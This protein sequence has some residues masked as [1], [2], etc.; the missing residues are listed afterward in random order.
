MKISQNET[1]AIGNVM[2]SA[3]G[4]NQLEAG[5]TALSNTAFE[6]LLPVQLDPE[7]Q[8]AN[9]YDQIFY[10]RRKPV[11][12][13]VVS[14]AMY[15]ELVRYLATV[16]GRI[17]A[18]FAQAR[19]LVSEARDLSTLPKDMAMTRAD[20]Y[21]STILKRAD[22]KD[23][24]ATAT[25]NYLE[26]IGTGKAH[27][28]KPSKKYKDG[29]DVIY[30]GLPAYGNTKGT[31]IDRFV[32]Q[33]LNHVM[34][35]GLRDYAYNNDLRGDS[36][37]LNTISLAKQSLVMCRELLTDLFDDATVGTVATLH[38]R[39][40]RLLPLDTDFAKLVNGAITAM[41]GQGVDMRELANI[42]KIDPNMVKGLGRYFSI[43][44]IYEANRRAVNQRINDAA[45]TPEG[46]GLN[47]DA[48]VLQPSI[49]FSLAIHLPSELVSFIT[50]TKPSERVPLTPLNTWA[51]IWTRALMRV[52]KAKAKKGER[53]TVLGAPRYVLSA[54][55]TADLIAR[56]KQLGF[57]TEEGRTNEDD[58]YVSN[59]GTFNFCPKSSELAMENA[60]N[61]ERL[62]EEALQV[63]FDAGTPLNASQLGETNPV[64]SLA[65]PEY[66]EK[67]ANMK[68]SLKRY[69]GSV[70]TYSWDYN[71][72]LT[73][74]KQDPDKL[75]AVNLAGAARPDELSIADYLRRPFANAMIKLF[76]DAKVGDE[77]EQNADPNKAPTK[78][79]SEETF[80]K[81]GT[82]MPMLRSSIFLNARKVYQY[83]LHDRSVP[84]FEQ[85][86]ENAAKAL[87]ITSLE[88]ERVIAYEKNLS[89][90]LLTADLKVAPTLKADTATPQRQVEA[91]WTLFERALRDSSGYPGS[92]LARACY[93]Q[94]ENIDENDH[95]FNAEHFTLAEFK[96]VYNYFGGQVFYQMLTALAHVD[97]KKLMVVNLENPEP[98]VNFKS[99][100]EEVM[101]LAM[102]MSKYVPQS[103][104]IYTKAD[105]LAEKNKKNTSITPQDIKVPGSKAPADGKAGMQMFPHQVET[106]QYLRN[107]PR[108]AVLDIAP[109]GGK[110]IAVLSD[111]ACLVRDRQISKP[112]IVCP[113]G[114][115]RNWVEDMHK[116]TQG[117]WNVIPITT[118]TYKT[119]GDERLT[120]MIANAPRNTVVV[121][122]LSVLQLQRY[123]VVI[124][125]HVEKVS[126]TL[127][128]VKK[129]GFDYVAVDESHR[130]KNVKTAT[131]KA[132]KQLATA[133]SIKF[134]RLATGTLISNTLT[135]V[136]GQAAMFSSQ[137][138]RTPEEYKA[139]NSEQVG[140]TKVWTWKKDTPLRARQQLA[141]HA[142]VITF[143]RKEWAF[144]LPFPKES[145]IA[146][147][148]EKKDSD[149]GNAHQLMYD[150][151]L[152][153]VIEELE[154]DKEIMKVLKGGSI[155]SAGDENG[156]DDD[157]DDEND[158]NTAEQLKDV[159]S[160]A[161]A[162]DK[163]DNLDDDAMAELEVMLKPYL[164]RLEMLLTDPIGDEWG[165]K[166]FKGLKQDD[167]IPNKVLKIIDRIKLN[168]QD[169]PWVKGK[170]YAKGGKDKNDSAYEDI[171]D[172]DGKRYVLLP[173]P[174]ANPYDREAYY[175][176]Y[177]STTPPDQ[178]TARW[179]PE[180]RGKVIVFCRYTRSVNAIYRA[181]AKLE[182][183]LAKVAVRFHG[184]I[185][186]KWANLDAFK[187][188]PV[189][190]NKGVQILIANEQAISEGHNLQMASRLIRVESPWAPGELDQSAARIFRPDPTGAFSRE[191]VY[192]DWIL[193]NGSMEVAKMGR[194]ISKM[195][196]K[197][198]FDE[199]NNP[200]YESIAD[201]QLPPISMGLETIKA[202]PLL[203]SISEYTDAY[204]ELARI[205]SAEFREMR[206]TRPSKMFDIDPEPMF[207]DAKLIEQTPYV[208]NMKVPDRHNFGL[209]PLPEYLQDTENADVAEILK[210][211]K[212]LIGEYAHTE[213]GNGV[214]TNVSFAR[215]DKDNPNAPRRIT[216]VYVKLAGS[217]EEYDG[218][219]GMIHMATNLTAETIKNFQ[220]P[221]VATK[222]DK[223]RAAKL[224]L[225]AAKKAA[226]LE[227]KL[228]SQK[229]K[230]AEKLKKLK[231]IE[232]LKDKKGK[233]SAPKKPAKPV[234]EEES[235][236]EDN[237][238]ALVYPVMYNGYLA[239]EID[240][241]DDEIDL[242]EYG[243]KRSGD[244]AY[245]G[246]PDRITFD[247]VLKALTKKFYIAKPILK[248]LQSLEET[249][250][251][252]K[253]R[254]FAV[255]QAPVSEFKNFYRIS[256]TM[257]KKDEESGKQ[258]LKVYPVILNGKLMLSVDIATNP[259]IRKLLNKAIPG[260]PKAKFKQADGLD[261]QF[262][263]KKS[264]ML[265]KVKQLTKE[266]FEF[267]NLEEFE[268]ELK[269]LNLKV[270]KTEK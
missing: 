252:G 4:M 229:K 3:P 12:G 270:G 102:V 55:S 143:K 164:Q 220:V 116:I 139:E 262:F 253:G 137:I 138:F 215:V 222:K 227:K 70:Q 21:L 242:E 152:A 81:N 240:V 226:A 87:N 207:E 18:V 126:G 249:F 94:G 178:D 170:T 46:L 104:Q 251:N 54:S 108:F 247:A 114:L 158:D 219:P 161:L 243:F 165:E 95:F 187:S 69:G 173:D 213:F 23:Q 157:D 266:G 122:G 112:M 51:S 198:Q 233:V 20:N 127:E 151:V 74:A 181:L 60:R 245:I 66:K 172:Y 9:D 36:G 47:E 86:V 223:E 133:S 25:K 13:S 93:A 232:K 246:I 254:K 56:R 208:P 153:A 17:N 98:Q 110:T 129:F 146:V 169:F 5:M 211:P 230:E 8:V 175:A 97:R 149:L 84:S 174:N 68:A 259:V 221:K 216:R 1:S 141:R 145:F 14:R 82:A 123:P 231:E 163:P 228:A 209:I 195:L 191:N 192:L 62:L 37:V 236:E 217:G 263:T 261:V 190:K 235:A 234:V 197:A 38:Q 96:N 44:V 7:S 52:P 189:D 109:G 100:V 65:S 155:D 154:K 58:L 28:L 132:V 41:K 19:Y 162:G 225:L 43:V 30:S 185:K 135:D 134:I 45:A 89:N 76:P 237:N 79:V 27:V 48:P 184:E 115:V 90:G 128:F 204:Q 248:R 6:A 99:V 71:C 15:P 168:F 167:F 31:A 120:R 35:E 238:R 241:E 201:Y 105:E 239:L 210:D 264:D 265:K 80:G 32:G 72:I 42:P 177:T 92:N 171:V 258:E 130:V 150:T 176:P 61:Y 22:D 59:V 11:K 142:A 159:L 194:L 269:A 183:N 250:A 67:I 24:I 199:A 88:D 39:K 106:H 64:F 218:A 77:D 244:Y 131:H 26:S 16:S 34:P 188:T 205:Q 63:S 73:S 144:M 53:V 196:V 156:A 113:N 267:Q 125:N 117:K 206:A 202:T 83:L 10:P 140:D 49:G 180:P 40:V 118:A 256:H 101:P 57:Y 29:F 136:I 203:S 148:M 186:E 78:N 212:K 75:V 33:G 166:F 2:D 260:A 50:Q 103:E 182:P 107:H 160:S 85:L 179:K 224:K 255:E 111:I 268:A 193:T 214:I 91:I 124:G 147:A 121:V 257:A 119:W 200:L